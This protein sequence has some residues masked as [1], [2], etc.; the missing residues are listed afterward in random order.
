MDAAAETEVRAGEVAA[1]VAAEHA[2]LEYRKQRDF[3]FP[4]DVD[5]G[6]AGA[7]SD[8]LHHDG[9]DF[10]IQTLV[11][12]GAHRIPATGRSRA[13]AGCGTA[14]AGRKANEFGVVHAADH[15]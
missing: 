11:R 5:R 9:N 4:R 1:I 6:S 10:G 12:A 15:G 8:Y 3:H 2:E 7:R 13:R 14:C